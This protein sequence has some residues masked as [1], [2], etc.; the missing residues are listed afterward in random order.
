MTIDEPKFP[1]LED[2]LRFLFDRALISEEED[3]VLRRALAP[4]VERFFFLD[5]VDAGREE[6]RVAGGPQ[7][8]QEDEAALWRKRSLI[9]NFD[10]EAALD[11]F[12]VTREDDPERVLVGFTPEIDATL[13]DV[14]YVPPALKNGHQFFWIILRMCRRQHDLDQRKGCPDDSKDPN[15]LLPGA[16]VDK[17]DELSKRPPLRSPEPPGALKRVWRAVV[18]E[19]SGKNRWRRL[20]VNTRSG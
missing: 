2:Y 18:D 4:L 16:V 17:V 11:L 10:L 3:A 9:A 7:A 15:H 12:L 6:I 8:L 13:Q 1:T 5:T 19:L 20:A 14:R